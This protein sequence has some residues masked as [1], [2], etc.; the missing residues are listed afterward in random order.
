MYAIFKN[1]DDA[2]VL[3]PDHRFSH[4]FKERDNHEV[5]FRQINTFLIKRG[6]IKGNIIDLGAWIGDNSI[7]WAK[8]IDS[9]IYA[10]DP[11]PENC[12]FITDVCALNKIDNVKVLQM[13]ISNTFEILRT[14]D[15]IEHCSFVYGGAEGEE[16]LVEAVNLDFL[17]K[18]RVIENVGYIHLDVEGMEYRIIQGSERLISGCRPIVTFEQHLE[19]DDVSG[20]ISH[21]S[22]RGYD[23]FMIDEILPGCR[24]DCRNFLAF[25]REKY[26]DALIL[27]INEK[28]SREILLRK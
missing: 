8:N 28:I 19:I 24:H 6:V 1:D 25:P 3:L 17:Y 20:I 15:N 2:C 7:P 22:N 9:T 12:D 26:T 16:K 4:M 14:K 10:I 21:V 11:S 18:S 5:L 23:V 27:E 13:A